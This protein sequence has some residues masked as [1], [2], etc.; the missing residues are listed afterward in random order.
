MVAKIPQ[1]KQNPPILPPQVRFS[2]GPCD[3]TVG[4]RSSTVNCVV[5]SPN[6]GVCLTM[7]QKGYRK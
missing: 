1:D 6:F 5:R 4:Q 7:D 2:R 3:V